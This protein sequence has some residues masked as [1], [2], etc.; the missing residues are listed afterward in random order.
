M[1]SRST[2]S[3]KDG[4]TYFSAA[5]NNNLFDGEGHEIASWEA[6][7]FRDAGA[8]PPSR[9]EPSPASTLFTASTS[10]RA[11]ATTDNTFGITVE[12]DETL[13]VDLQ[14]AEPWFGVGTDLDAFLLDA[15]GEL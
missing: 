4:V 5:G 1:R 9:R 13:S 15:N 12:P 3:T 6:P 10:T 8:C 14:W 2:T 7:A 11:S